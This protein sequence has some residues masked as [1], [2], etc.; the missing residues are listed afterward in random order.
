MRSVCELDRLIKEVKFDMEV[1]GVSF[2]EEC[3]IKLNNKLS[4]ALGRCKYRRDWN[5]SMYAY[6]I[7]I[8]EMYFESAT[9]NE[10]KST[11]CHELIHSCDKCINTQCHHKG[12]WKVYAR[13][14]EV[15]YPNKYLIKR[16]TC[17]KQYNEALRKKKENSYKYEVYCPKCGAT[18]RRKS[19]CKLVQ[20]PN[21]YSCGRCNADLK[22]RV[23]GGK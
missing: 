19:K 10:L 17:S 9:D 4:R 1:V 5:G 21:Y 16:I 22:V 2:N 7:E 3:P 14:M 20:H 18:W 23:I 8:N 12:L 11:I 6:V 15:N 13:R